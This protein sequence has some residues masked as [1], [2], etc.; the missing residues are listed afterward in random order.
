MIDF[1]CTYT[2]TYFYLYIPP[3]GQLNAHLPAQHI[4][5]QTAPA[6]ISQKHYPTRRVAA[7]A[8]K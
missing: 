1:L 8:Y 2:H 3:H 4:L 7:A 5:I 6:A